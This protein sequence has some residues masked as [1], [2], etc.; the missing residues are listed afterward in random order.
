[1]ELPYRGYETGWIAKLC[2]MFPKPITTY[3]VEC[4]GEVD[5]GRVDVNILLFAFLCEL[6]CYKNK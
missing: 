5:I 6:H 1:M 3:C 4:F 2:H